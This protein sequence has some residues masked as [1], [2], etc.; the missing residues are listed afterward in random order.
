VISPRAAKQ[1]GLLEIINRIKEE[2]PTVRGLFPGQDCVSCIRSCG[3]ATSDEEAISIGND[4]LDFGF[5]SPLLADVGE[6][7]RRFTNSPTLYMISKT[8]MESV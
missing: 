6:G 5:I 7:D 8:I 2:L 1:K 4:L 3:L